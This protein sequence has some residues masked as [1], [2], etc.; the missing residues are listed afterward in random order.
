MLGHFLW[1][2]LILTLAFYLAV[3]FFSLTSCFHV[4]FLKENHSLARHRNWAKNQELKLNELPLTSHYV[5]LIKP[6]NPPPQTR[7][8]HPASAAR[9]DGN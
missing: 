9:E 2:F 4:K 1:H 5:S 6:P 7:V 8:S 3:C